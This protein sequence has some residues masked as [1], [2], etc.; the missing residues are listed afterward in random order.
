M[1]GSGSPPT[2]RPSF[3]LASPVAPVRTLSTPA[4]A[5]AVATFLTAHALLVAWYIQRFGH[6]PD[7]TRYSPKPVAEATA[8]AYVPA[9]PRHFQLS[10]IAWKQFRESGPT[11]L[12]GFAGAFAIAVV[13]ATATRISYA[14]R[15]STPPE[16]FAQLFGA[17]WFVASI[18]LGA[19]T[20][21]VIGIGIFL[22]DLEP[23]LNT[24]WRSRPISPGKWYWTKF[25]SGLAVVGFAF[26]LPMLLLV[27]LAFCLYGHTDNYFDW[28]L[29]A[30]GVSLAIFV[31]V[32]AVAVAITCL[33]RHAVYAG[34]LT[35]STTYLGDSRLSCP[36]LSPTGSPRTSGACECLTNPSSFGTGSQGS[37]WTRL[38]APLSA[39]SPFATTGAAKAGLTRSF[40]DCVPLTSGTKPKLPSLSPNHSSPRR[41]KR[42]IC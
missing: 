1:T 27:F 3:L 14:S 13:A 28:A 18:Y 11:A 33:V 37:H 22:R 17:A 19:I 16:D 29:N 35:I 25:A 40:N 23:A 31:A 4:G 2:S 21:L 34:I 32:F 7:R 9:K 36:S 10:A 5:A 15:N 8:F 39:G 6:V 38:S 24:F 20:A 41:V 12:V 42:T 26:Q 30:Q